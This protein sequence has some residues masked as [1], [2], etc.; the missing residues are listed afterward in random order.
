MQEKRIRVTIRYSA[1]AGLRPFY[2]TVANQIKSTHPDVLLENRILPAISS[3]GGDETI[4]DVLV[5]GKL[6][7]GKKKSK[8]LKVSSR[9]DGG[10]SDEGKGEDGA[11]SEEK[12]DSNT[13][14]DIAGGR[15]LFVSME[16]I[17]QQLHKA[18]KR[19]RPSTMYKTKEEI[20]RGAA[21]DMLEG[22]VGGEQPSSENTTMGSEGSESN[23]GYN[24]PP[25]AAMTEAV[26][27]LEKLK[28]MSTR[29]NSI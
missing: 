11:K 10:K 20:L 14:P 28:A 25:S 17:E 15:S 22:V 6:V 23:N 13:T 21:M 16:L 26:M 7:I 19:R 9:S 18:R 2:L 5:D 24:M 3:S 1:D 29:K 27:R 4:F 8:M 12:K